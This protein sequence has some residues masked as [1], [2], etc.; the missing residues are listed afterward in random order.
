[1]RW[2]PTDLKE[3]ALDTL[4]LPSGACL[5]CD[6]GKNPVVLF[7]NEGSA[8]DFGETNQGVPLAALPPSTARE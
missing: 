5:A 1:V 8:G 2:L 6:P 7:L 3:D 4:S